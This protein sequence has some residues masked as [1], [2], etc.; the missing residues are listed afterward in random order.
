[1]RGERFMH[2]RHSNPAWLKAQMRVDPHGI[3]RW[4]DSK[5]V[6]SVGIL[7]R[8]GLTP[9]E[10]ERHADARNLDLDKFAAKHIRQRNLRTPEEIAEERAAAR[11]A[12]GPGVE[13]VNIFTGEKLMT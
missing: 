13:L 10:L 12:H 6:P 4:R 3:H 1:M 8:L 7:N 2:D 5:Q 9:V 11:V